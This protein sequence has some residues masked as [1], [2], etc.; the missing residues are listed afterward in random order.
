M[1]GEA[2]KKSKEFKGE[3]KRLALQ[4]VDVQAVA[5]AS[6]VQIAME[7][8]RVEVEPGGLAREWA[9]ALVMAKQQFAE[10]RRAREGQDA[11]KD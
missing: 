3:L 5:Q 8:S 11:A 2:W 6:S 4:C 7:L 10:A 9:G 1:K